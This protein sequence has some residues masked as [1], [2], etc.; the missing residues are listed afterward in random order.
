MDTMYRE[1]FG[2]RGHMLYFVCVFKLGG[3]PLVNKILFMKSSA[4]CV[5]IVPYYP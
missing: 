4:R 3:E 5:T 2:E 1:G